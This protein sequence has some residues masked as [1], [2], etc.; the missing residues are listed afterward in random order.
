MKRTLAW[1]G[2]C[3]VLLGAPWA[4]EGQEE[5]PDYEYVSPGDVAFGAERALAAMGDRL[6]VAGKERLE[7][8]GTLTQGGQ[9]KEV[10]I[11]WE[12]PGKVRIEKRSDSE[13]KDEGSDEPEVEEVVV[14]DGR[15]L[16]R[17][18]GTAGTAEQDLIE[19]LVHDSVEGFFLGQAEGLATRFLGSR[20]H[21]EDEE[22]TRWG[23][24]TISTR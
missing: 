9:A 20:F 11:L 24:T 3:W 12:S 13:E 5:A 18:R 10:R 7:L 6:Q 15:I 22:G 17:T 19:L 23:R 4:A 2:V 8:V 14:Y 16:S 21:E 1:T